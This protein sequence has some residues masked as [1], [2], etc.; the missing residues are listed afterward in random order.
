MYALADTDVC[1]ALLKELK[2]SPQD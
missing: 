1:A 2:L